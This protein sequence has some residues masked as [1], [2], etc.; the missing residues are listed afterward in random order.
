MI[1]SSQLIYDIHLG[2][3][4]EIL[5]RTINYRPNGK[6]ANTKDILPIYV[7]L[8]EDKDGNIHLVPPPGSNELDPRVRALDPKSIEREEA[9]ARIFV[10]KVLPWLLENNREGKGGP[11]ADQAVL[12]AAFAIHSKLGV[13][14]MGI[15]ELKNL[16]GSPENKSE[17]TRHVTNLNN[18]YL[19]SLD[20]QINAEYHHETGK[21]FVNGFA[22]TERRPKVVYL[23]NG[24]TK[25]IYLLILT[26]LDVIENRSRESAINRSSEDHIS[27]FRNKSVVWVAENLHP[28][29][30]G[31]HEALL[32][33]L[34]K[35]QDKILK[36][37]YGDTFYLDE[38]GQLQ[39]VN[40]DS[41]TD[42][43]PE[44][45]SLLGQLN[46]RIW[47][48]PIYSGR[49]RFESPGYIGNQTLDNK[50]N[51]RGAIL[52]R[53]W[54]ER[55]KMES[56]MRR[57]GRILNKSRLISGTATMIWLLAGE[58]ALG[59]HEK[60]HKTDD[61]NHR[62]YKD[63]KEREMLSHTNSITDEESEGAEIFGI[64][65]LF[66]YV[67][68]G[69][70][71]LGYK[72]VGA[73][74]LSSVINPPGFF[75]RQTLR[76]V[77]WTEHSPQPGAK[78]M[79]YL[80]MTLDFVASVDGAIGQFI[81]LFGRH[82][83]LTIKMT[84]LFVRNLFAFKSSSLENLLIASDQNALDLLR[85]DLEKM[86]VKTITKRVKARA[87][88]FDQEKGEEEPKPAAAER[89][90]PPS[91]TYTW[92]NP[93]AG[94]G[95]PG[96]DDDKK[97]SIGIPGP[98]F[99]PVGTPANLF[100]NDQKNGARFVGL[101]QALPVKLT[102]ARLVEPFGVAPSVDKDL[103]AGARFAAWVVANHMQDS[104][105]TAIQASSVS[106]KALDPVEIF[107]GL[108]VTLQEAGVFG[109]D[110]AVIINATGE[111]MGVDQVLASFESL[112]PNLLNRGPMHFGI[113]LNASDA[114]N[115]ERI[116]SAGLTPIIL[117]NGED[118]LA[119]VQRSLPAMKIS[120]LSYVSMAL[121]PEQAMGSRFS[122]SNK[123]N[124]LIATRRSLKQS[125][126]QT[127]LLM[128]NALIALTTK[129]STAMTTG[130]TQSFN[131]ELKSRLEAVGFQQFIIVSSIL[132]FIENF[133]SAG[134]MAAQSA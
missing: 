21:L 96:G 104:V 125:K 99:V 65:Q 38:Y 47:A 13:E 103:Y 101:P 3:G 134:S 8:A 28:I 27:I 41:V 45:I 133:L 88:S 112:S 49:L 57:E 4:N 129:N 74:V 54:S 5:D 111:G 110:R 35:D 70:S 18:G 63:Q 84:P 86:D 46:Q 126:D 115:A 44:A 2:K 75:R 19:N 130:L 114:G 59:V 10:S 82:P 123:P 94:G 79:K 95:A 64:F 73:D 89:N 80:A 76:L 131:D 61:Y 124:L 36:T 17:L 90:L 97:K 98:V 62:Y 30:S 85:M 51:I 108:G 23:K 14:V 117:G 29:A 58:V 128:I 92:F 105:N 9:Q 26:D 24:D 31:Q 52:N 132:R 34:K 20:L 87:K 78:K 71:G 42:K 7:S 102:S 69:T 15:L 121:S 43:Y 16:K 48:T 77:S 37:G 109:K 32:K 93:V 55:D 122:A 116:T 11:M 72:R 66:G 127:T 68:E 33:D 113:L 83:I 67:K 81:G 1:L 12:D 53:A 25:K 106:S 119:A 100:N 6:V 40:V 39:F 118:P 107:Y 50:K 120:D 22:I 91:G 56:E 60:R